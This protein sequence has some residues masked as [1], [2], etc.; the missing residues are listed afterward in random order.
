MYT[1]YGTTSS[2]LTFEAQIYIVSSR[3][4]KACVEGR[5]VVGAPVLTSCGARS[6]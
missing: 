3:E 4:R 1:P 5:A 6:G 2:P